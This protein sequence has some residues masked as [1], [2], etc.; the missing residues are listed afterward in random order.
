M[1][2]NELY[3][4]APVRDALGPTLRPGGEVLTRRL[5]EHLLLRK[6]DFVLD[7]G[8]GCGAT[9]ALLRE[10]G[11][12]AVGLDRHAGLLREA[13]ALGRNVFRADMAA[14]PLADGCVDVVLSECAWN[15]AEKGRTLEEFVRVLKPGGRLALADIYV[16]GCC[17]GRWP[18]HCCFAQ[19]TDL[20]TV[21]EQVRAVGLE[22]ETV[23]DQ[24]DLLKRAAAEF[25]LRHGSLRGFWQAVT[26]GEQAAEAACAAARDA[27]PGL[28]ALVARRPILS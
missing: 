6:D 10:C 7:A 19:A 4:S 27:R 22:V 12:L 3:V 9:V 20:Q 11:C 17:S 14:I 2:T 24:T 1:K 26:G 23:E 5:L 21:L 18:V 15:L 16:R 25:V 8:C 13:C 28:F